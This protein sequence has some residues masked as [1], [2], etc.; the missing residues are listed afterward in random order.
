MRENPEKSQKT[1]ETVETLENSD[2]ESECRCKTNQFD[3]AFLAIINL[4]CPSNEQTFDL[5]IF[6]SF[7]FALLFDL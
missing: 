6:L 4:I 3:G 7:F 2:M 5:P 1:V